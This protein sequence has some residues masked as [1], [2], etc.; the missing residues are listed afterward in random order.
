MISLRASSLL[1]WQAQNT[2]LS[3]A[4]GS[5]EKAAARAVAEA[6]EAREEAASASAAA[7]EVRAAAQDLQRELAAAADAHERVTHG[8]P[9]RLPPHTPPH[10]HTPS[11]T[12]TQLDPPIMCPLGILVLFAT[13]QG[14]Q[15]FLLLRPVRLNPV[16]EGPEVLWC[17]GAT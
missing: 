16:R 14:E 10:V 11:R 4:K 8:I 7:A 6:R 17:Q 2:D 5:A 1:C 15:M 13:D 9:S 3:A 12:H